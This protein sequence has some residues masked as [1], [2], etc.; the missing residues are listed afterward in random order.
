MT[1][2][3]ITERAIVLP[4]PNHVNPRSPA[5]IQVWLDDMHQIITTAER[6]GVPIV[7]FIVARGGLVVSGETL[8][9]FD[10]LTGELDA[11]L[12]GYPEDR[13]VLSPQC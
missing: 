5:E 8:R 11:P 3:A 1:D 9:I 10:E 2:Q 6:H 13:G 4:V 12:T 7:D